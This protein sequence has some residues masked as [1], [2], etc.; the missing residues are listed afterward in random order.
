MCHNI[1]FLWDN[2]KVMMLIFKHVVLQVGVS[3]LNQTV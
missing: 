1:Q 2:L 3:G